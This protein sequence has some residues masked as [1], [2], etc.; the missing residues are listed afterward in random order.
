MIIGTYVIQSFII[1]I[2]VIYRRER[3]HFGYLFK[4]SIIEPGFF[5]TPIASKDN[6][7][8]SVTTA[9]KRLSDV[10]K[11]EFPESMLHE[12]KNQFKNESANDFVE[13]QKV[14]ISLVF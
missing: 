3:K 5:A 4:V 12:C 7:S 9:W 10:Q 6:L 11:R 14:V 13:S 1:I 2:F 8:R